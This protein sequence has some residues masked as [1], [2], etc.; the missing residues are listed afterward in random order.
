MCM[1]TDKVGAF[2]AVLESFVLTE[3]KTQMQMCCV[4]SSRLAALNV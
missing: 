3:L 4:D 2:S 1:T